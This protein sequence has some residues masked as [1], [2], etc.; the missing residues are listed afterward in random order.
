V[1]C[2][3]HH[4]CS[5]TQYR[6]MKVTDAEGNKICR[7]RRQPPLPVDADPQGW[8]EEM[9]MPY[10]EDVYLLLE[11]MGLA[12][13]EEDFFEPDGK[14]VVDNS[15][16]AGKWHYYATQNEFFLAT[17]PLVSAICR[18]STNV[19]MCDR[20]FQVS[21]L[22][23]YVAGKEE[24]QL[25]D[26][27]G[28]KDVTEAKITTE[29][30]GH[31][32]ITNCKKLLS[33][34]EKQSAHLGREISL[35]EVV[36]FLLGFP[37]TYCTSDFISVGTLPLEHRVGILRCAKQKN[38]VLASSN[39][40]VLP[41]VAGRVKA[42]LPDWRCFSTGQLVHIE[43][44]RKS[45][46]WCDATSS[47]N[48]RP[49]E[50][51]FFDNL[52][53]YCECFVV[54]GTQDC[55]FESEVA[56]QL[57]FDGLS[58]RVLLRSCSVEKAVDFV[59]MKVRLQNSDAAEMLSSVFVPIV[60]GLDGFCER[61]IQLSSARQMV[62]VISLVKPWD[63]TKFVGH[64]CL[65]L[66]RYTCE[67]DLFCSGSVRFAFVQAGLLPADCPVTRA[68][69]LSLLRSY[70]VEDLRFHPISARQFAKYIKAALRTLTDVLLDDAVDDYTPC[71]T[72]IMLKEQ[73]S[74]VL[75]TKEE[76]RKT[77]LVTAL[78]DDPVVRGLLPVN[79]QDATLTSPVDWRP[80]ILQVDG[81]SEDTVKE[82][83]AALECCLQA[84][85]KFM[86]PRCRGLKFPC[87]VGRAGSG[88]SHVCK[89]AVA[90]SLSKGLQVELMSWTSERGRKLGGN[91]L[92]IVFPL[93]VSNSKITFSSTIASSCLAKLQNDPL[94]TAMLKRTDVF[95]FEEIG[96]LSAEFFAALDNILR[97]LMGNS[98]PWG[99]KLLLSCGDSKQLPPIDGR[100]I[101]GS[102]NMCTMMQIFVFSCDVRARDAKL[103]W[104]NSE[105]R[106]Q[107]NADECK[108]V[109]DAIVAECQFEPDWSHVPDVAVRIVPT[110]AA[111]LKVMEE[112]LKDRNTKSYCAVDEVQNGAIWEKAGDMISKQLNRRCYEYDVCKLYVNA[113]VRMTYNCRH[114]T[115]TVFSQG[116]VAIVVELPADNVEFM[117]KR[118]HLRLAPPGQRDIDAHNIPDA[119][120][121][122]EVGPRTTLPWKVYADGPSHT[123]SGAVLLM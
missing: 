83:T 25:V 27:A 116:Q 117:L 65:S 51:L 77:N 74:D 114:G 4:D 12:H 76:L 17:I 9:A 92:H 115:T 57:W 41:V 62:S 26:V 56:D 60:K 75:R 69:I 11:E 97:V 50:L 30:H 40:D 33:A 15:L 64:L 81:I 72:D 91:H 101:W 23:K 109:A 84:V 79:L 42:K 111:E 10:P 113:V 48:I 55:H 32:K 20:K 61:F 31:E 71:V 36:W 98:L 14:W 100:P 89:L 29:E 37:Y 35:A 53:L 18:S 95:M 90:Y 66:G 1:D 104:L 6:C 73:A 68:D 47:F 67:A 49:P 59:R 46:Y 2:V 85:D 44:Y 43:D 96:L 103:C 107:L 19:D 110:K 70:V 102:I 87:L 88:K 80:Q 122:V 5:K 24:H 63:R 45:P 82:Q 7:Y 21:Y 86:N 119:W 8:F 123:I 38:P 28:T 93:G 106:R 94:A 22:V 99:G 16:Q 121:K 3:Q 58:R 105:C 34:K 39:T 112:F 120:P 54:V 78:Y 13:K 108:A 118:L 52:Q